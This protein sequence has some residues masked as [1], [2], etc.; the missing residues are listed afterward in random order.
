[1]STQTQI[2]HGHYVEGLTTLGNINITMAHTR[3]LSRY[4][5]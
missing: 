2:I 1:M 3:W 5:P 4:V